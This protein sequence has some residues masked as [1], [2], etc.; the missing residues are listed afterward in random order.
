MTRFRAP[1]LTALLGLTVALAAFAAGVELEPQA[2]ALVAD[3]EALGVRIDACPKGDCA[4]SQDIL[5]D[6]DSLDLEL[7]DLESTR[8]AIQNC[9]DCAT[10]DGL[11]DDAGALSASATEQT[12][13]WNDA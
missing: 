9:T 7:A 5:D 4:E 12:G 2:S 8:A 10:L 1:A 13:G 11:L 3:Y 6:L